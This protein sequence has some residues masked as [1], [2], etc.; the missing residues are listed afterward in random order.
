VAA[1]GMVLTIV[2]LVAVA[3]FIL[4]FERSRAR[5]IE[6]DLREQR[7]RRDGTPRHPTD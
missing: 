5:Q 1:L 3:V 4:L 7:D 2:V 6:D